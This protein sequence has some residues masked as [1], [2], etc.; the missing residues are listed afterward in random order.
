MKIFMLM[1]FLNFSGASKMFLWVANTLSSAG[2]DVT[3]YVFSN[4]VT[5]KPETGISFINENLANKGII[6][7]IHSVR[8]IIKK[9]DADVSIS[10]LLDANVYN[11]FACLGLKTKSV[12]CERNDPFKPHYYKLK[13]W[14]PFFRFADGGVF[15]LKKVAEYYS[16]IKGKT[17]VIPNPA[18]ITS[19]VVLRPFEEREKNIVTLGR[20]AI[21]QKRNDLQIKAFALFHKKHPNYKLI[22]YG[23]SIN[24]DDLKLQELIKEEGLTE[25]V[26]MPGVIDNV[27]ETIKNSQI[28]LLTSDYEG[29]PNTLMEAMAIGLPCISTD[30]R[31]GGA[32][33]LIKNE[34]NGLLVPCGDSKQ[35]ADKL[36]WLAEHPHEADSIGRNAKN[37]VKDLSGEKIKSLWIKFLKDLCQSE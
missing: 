5:H 31:P 17:A 7:K 33:L 30:C 10:F 34:F 32:S 12:I 2:H 9:V 37:I 18:V 16:N 6:G 8:N 26:C 13:F 22:I 11:T 24:G 25:S 28:Y 35:M 20:I 1:R 19:K 15:Q 14:K 4:N 21:E 29:I 27:Q 23:R 3:V 36:C